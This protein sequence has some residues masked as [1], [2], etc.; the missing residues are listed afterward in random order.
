MRN[1]PSLTGAPQCS[2]RLLPLLS[3]HH[4]RRHSLSGP[5]RDFFTVRCPDRSPQSWPAVRPTTAPRTPPT[6]PTARRRCRSLRRRTPGTNGAKRWIF[7]C[8]SSVLR[9]TWETFGGFRTFVIKTAVVSLV[10]ALL[11]TGYT[12][13]RAACAFNRFIQFEI[14]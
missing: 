5:L 12:I 1:A 9:W 6:A 14:S 10:S 11:R 3:C 2:E 13:Y 8:L 7:S 4:H